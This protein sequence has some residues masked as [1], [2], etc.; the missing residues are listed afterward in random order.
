MF[1]SCGRCC[2]WLVR[3]GVLSEFLYAYD[4]VLMSETIEG[5]M[6]K[7][8]DWKE[9]FESMGLK[10]D[11]WKTKVMVSSGFIKGWHV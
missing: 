2:H 4:L 8:L 1:C 7:F 9:S 10:V 5:L 11:L 6:N 3:D